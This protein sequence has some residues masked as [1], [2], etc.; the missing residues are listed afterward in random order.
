MNKEILF[1]QTLEAV[2][3]TA[4]EQGNCISEEQVREAFAALELGEDQL[5]LVYDYLTKHKI[6]IGQPVDLDEYLTDGERNYLQ[7]Y[8]EEV[9]L[10]EPVNEGEKEA[11]TLSAMAGDKAAQHRLVELYLKDVVDIARLYAGQG[12]F[13]EDLIG[14]GNVALTLGSGML[15]C[16]EHASE[17]QGMLGKLI[18]DAMEQYISENAAKEKVDRRVEEQVNLVMEKAKLLAEELQRKVTP[19]EL[20]GEMELS[21]K[22][23][24]DAVRMSGFHDEYIQLERR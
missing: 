11:V 8:L 18:M 16:L 7:E 21:L 3:K 24:M 2:K 1:A 13:L 15:G 5:G 4:R 9:S 22:T 10:L 20:A 17:A 23:V 6:G 14:E 12:V 19:E